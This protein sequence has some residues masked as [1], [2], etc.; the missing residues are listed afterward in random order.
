MKT[1]NEAKRQ[2][3]SSLENRQR[4]FEERVNRRYTLEE[5]LSLLIENK[6]RLIDRLN[7]TDEQKQQLKAFFQK[8]PNYESK[9]D[10][11]NKNL[12]WESF[13][14]ILETDGKSR[15]Q[16][17]KYGI[18][19]I[20]EGKD[21]KLIASGKIGY[22]QTYNI[23]RPLTYLGSVTLA[24]KRVSPFI[25]G[26]WCVAS[27]DRHYWDYYTIDKESV[28]YYILID[29]F[30]GGD[31][32][33]IALDCQPEQ[34]EAWDSHDTNV[35]GLDISSGWVD[36]SDVRNIYKGASEEF[37]FI[38]KFC[39]VMKQCSK[40]I[41]KDREQSMQDNASNAIARYENSLES[42]FNENGTF[43]I[44]ILVTFG[45]SLLKVMDAYGTYYRNHPPVIVVPA[46]YP[47]DYFPPK[48]LN[49]DNTRFTF[50]VDDWDT[51]ETSVFENVK[52]L[53][54]S[55]TKIKTL[56]SNY[57]S[58]FGDIGEI[59]FPNTLEVID[60]YAFA[61]NNSLQTIDLSRTKL[62]SIGEYAFDSCW[63]V[64]SL[65]LPGTVREFG[66]N[67][68]GRC[69]NLEDMS[70]NMPLDNFMNL[71]PLKTFEISLNGEKCAP[72]T[73]HSMVK[74]KK[75]FVIYFSDQKV[76]FSDLVDTWTK[77]YDDFID[78][79]LNK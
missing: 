48:E 27:N 45:R 52:R 19:G 21:Y 38:S 4:L 10:W 42:L 14:D 47:Y 50:R 32:T 25:E 64:G 37:V 17:K 79:N 29:D 55:Q 66:F 1:W 16:A 12:T 41:E 24:S 5:R 35:F 78:S 22:G 53:D 28:F 71:F 34:I 60:K 8:H 43:N 31:G 54:L 70:I 15:S 40:I 20:T 63:Q 46:N 59:E 36:L 56:K 2:Y 73:F 72:K 9:I 51:E 7:L 75:N 61:Y 33:K 74:M 13:S 58:I 62:T 3:R 11:N 26:E 76:M 39:E 77:Q 6:D 57:T 18:S 30:D 23:Y 49:N 44:D 67:F 69:R 65:M 68:I